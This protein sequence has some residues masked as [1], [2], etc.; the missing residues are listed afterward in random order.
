ML[1]GFEADITQRTCV[2]YNLR[3]GETMGKRDSKKGNTSDNGAGGDTHRRAHWLL[4]EGARLLRQQRPDEAANRL[5]R[6]RELDPMNVEVA[7]NLGGAYVMQ[8]HHA[9]AVPVL[10]EA[11][12]ADPDHVMV[13]INLAAAYL[14]YLEASDEDSQR[15]AI[16]AFERALALDPKAPSVNYNLGLIYKQRGEIEKA[17]AHFWRALD[18]DPS[19][20]DARIRLRQLGREDTTGSPDT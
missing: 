9:K 18:V 4:N 1:I 12:R 6:A 16:A 20:N 17:A 3:V 7:I 14:G 8:G 5:E 15:K 19:D 10:E 13:W 11:S 2:G